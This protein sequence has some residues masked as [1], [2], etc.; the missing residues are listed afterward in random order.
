MGNNE[1]TS[2]NLVDIA[3]GLAIVIVLIIVIAAALRYVISGVAWFVA[4]LLGALSSM[5]AAIVVAF[6][7][8]CVSIVTVVLGTLLNSYLAY[9]QKEREYLRAHRED[10]YRQLISMFVRVLKRSKVRAEYS[11]DEMLE[12][13]YTFTENLM[14]WGSAD[15]I[16]LWSE[17]RIKAGNNPTPKELMFGQEQIILQLRKDMGQKRKLPQGSILKLFINDVDE[18]L[19]K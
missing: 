6:V 9:R 12:D 19:L 10:T 2:T 11:Q 7:T 1:D 8:G 16:K 13:I 18:Q 14:L 3:K 4:E 5:D 15:A 17:W